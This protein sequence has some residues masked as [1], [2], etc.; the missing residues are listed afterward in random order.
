MILSS[1]KIILGNLFFPFSLILLSNGLFSVI[2]G[3][4]SG[5][6]VLWVKV[7]YIHGALFE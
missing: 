4:Q 1:V 5:F 2:C 7:R 6:I 3:I